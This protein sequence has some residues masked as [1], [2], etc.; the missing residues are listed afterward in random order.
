[1]LE[2]MIFIKINVPNE[3]IFVKLGSNLLLLT[4]DMKGLI[5][6]LT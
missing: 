2:P 4:I 6:C 5:T 1:M 3:G